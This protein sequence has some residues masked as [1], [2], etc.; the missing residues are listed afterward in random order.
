MAHTP[1]HPYDAASEIIGQQFPSVGRAN[2]I[3]REAFPAAATGDRTLAE[4]GLLPKRGGA[5]YPPANVPGRYTGPRNPL[6]PHR[7][8]PG[9]ASKLGRIISDDAK[10][11]GVVV[12]IRTWAGR[13]EAHGIDG[14]TILAAYEA[15]GG[16]ADLSAEQRGGDTSDF[17]HDFVAGLVELGADPGVV[18]LAYQEAGGRLGQS[19]GGSGR[20]AGPGGFLGDAT[21]AAQ[22]AVDDVAREVEKLFR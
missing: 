20:G 18:A 2:L 14:G 3:L 8:S 4:A 11:P 13:L 22:K 6:G 10:R 15:A 1:R 17:L 7:V 12:D 16:S 21:N 9:L 19:A 5:Y